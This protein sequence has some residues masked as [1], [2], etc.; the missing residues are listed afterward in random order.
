MNSEQTETV[1]NLTETLT[2]GIVVPKMRRD[3][4][5]GCLTRRGDGKPW[6]A[7]WMHN[8]KIYTKSTRTTDKAAAKKILQTLTAPFQ[9]KD[10]LD[11]L[12][13]L[14]DVTEILAKKVAKPEIAITELW[15]VYEAKHVWASTSD[16]AKHNYETMIHKLEDWAKRHGCRYVSDITKDKALAFAKERTEEISIGTWNNALTQY[17]L[18]WETLAGCKEYNIIADAWKM[19]KLEDNQNQS[20]TRE[21]FTPAEIKAIISNA[22]DDMQLLTLISL[23]TGMRLID[24]ALLRWDE[25][26]MQHGQLA[27]KTRKRGVWVRMSIA[28][29]LYAALEDAQKTATGDYV[30]ERNAEAYKNVK[31][32]KYDN[33]AGTSIL[34]DR[35]GAILDKCDIKRNS[36]DDKG[37]T[38]ILKSFHSLRHTHA[39]A[40]YAEG[41]S[42]DDVAKRIGDTVQTAAK[43]VHHGYSY[44]LKGELTDAVRAALGRDLRKVA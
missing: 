39:S 21:P 2:T 29:E 15:K 27:V 32:G 40:Y 25:L 8:G 4:H 34:G 44:T 33:K 26:D 20:A 3:N 35:F 24:C 28:P 17:Q 22:D 16:G 30:N 18:V 1:N 36:Q 6:I 41:A 37:R 7:R 13:A 14:N 10:E 43:Y 23:Y 12:Q 42:M 5:T 31:T 9:H 19:D 38:H 11:V